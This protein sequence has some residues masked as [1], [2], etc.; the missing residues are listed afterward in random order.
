MKKDIIRQFVLIV[1]FIATVVVNGLANALPLNGLTTGSISD[2]FAVYFVPAG[3]VFSIWG[4]IYLLLLAFTVYQALPSQRENP[5]LR[6]VGYLPAVA[7]VFNA[8][9]IF[10]WHYEQFPLTLL[11]MAALLATLI[12]IY[13]RFDIGRAQVS[14]A[15]K[16]LT[17]IPFSV[18]LGWITVAAVANATQLLYMSNWDGFGISAVAWGVIMLIVAGIVAGAVIFTRRDIAYTLVILWAYAGIV[19]KHSAT[20]TIA[21]AAGV[22]AVAVAVM[23]IAA[24][25]MRGN[26]RISSRPA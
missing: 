9:W 2:R 17:H 15:A 5:V 24:Y 11:V 6:R 25:V 10:L 4:V 13:L 16:W 7:G 23:L 14:T 12:V 1:A 21:I 18:Y 26:A 20:P 22:V 3:Y 19:V 8:V